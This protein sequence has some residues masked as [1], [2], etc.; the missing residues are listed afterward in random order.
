MTVRTGEAAMWTHPLPLT[1]THLPWWI[2]KFP[3]SVSR[4]LDWDSSKAAPD[5]K[6][7][8]RSLC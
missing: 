6:P 5:Y 3:G 2:I 4:W 8:A 1:K 7:K